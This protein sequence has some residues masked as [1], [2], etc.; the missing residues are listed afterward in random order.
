[1]KLCN[2]KNL[3]KSIDSFTTIKSRIKQEEGMKYSLVMEY[4]DLG[5]LEHYTKNKPKGI[6]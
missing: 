5:D 1:M 6:L 4:C 3:I 2:H